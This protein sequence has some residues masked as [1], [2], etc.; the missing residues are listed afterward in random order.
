[1]T[2]IRSLFSL[3]PFCQHITSSL[4]LS[5]CFSHT[6]AFCT[7]EVTQI[8]SSPV[9]SHTFTFL[10]NNQSPALMSLAS[11]KSFLLPPV[12][13]NHSFLYSHDTTSLF[14]FKYYSIQLSFISRYLDRLVAHRGKKPIISWNMSFQK[15]TLKSRLPVPQNVDYLETDLYQGNQGKMRSYGGP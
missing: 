5:L 15:F 4:T 3:E 10:H 6:T 13:I 8:L 12:K 1:M 9:H 2:Q 14:L 11:L 7:P